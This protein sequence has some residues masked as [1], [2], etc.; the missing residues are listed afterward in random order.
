MGYHELMFG[1]RRL[2]PPPSRHSPGTGYLSTTS[3]SLCSCLLAS[4][5]APAIAAPVRAPE[6]A[7]APTDHERITRQLAYEARKRAKLRSRRPSSDRSR[8]DFPNLSP[9]AAKLPKMGF[10]T[11]QGLDARSPLPLAGAWARAHERPQLPDLRRRHA[12]L[13][14]LDDFGHTF[15]LGERFVYDVEFANSPIGVIDV[16]VDAIE[17][18]VRGPAPKGRPLVRL[19]A[20]VNTSG[21]LTFLA[22]VQDTMTSW[23]DART[24]AVVRIHNTMVQEGIGTKYRDRET[25]SE[26]LGRGYVRIIDTK[27]GKTRKLSL[28]VPTDTFGP[29]STVAWIRSLNLAPGERR[30]AHAMDMRALLRVEVVNRGPSTPEKMPSIAGALGLGA[31]DLDLYEG[32]L[33]RV[34]RHDDPLPGRRVVQFRAWVGRP[35]PRVLLALESD[36]WLGV[37]RLS[38]TGYDP[39]R[40]ASKAA[41]TRSAAPSMPPRAEPSPPSQVAGTSE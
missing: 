28:T 12:A 7:S 19:V 4:A 8:V 9:D 32:E 23:V 26:F 11:M 17:P 16:R 29:L 5:F 35:E 14:E 30:K 22:N 37:I 31:N 41:N 25:L 27:D 18:D 10:G 24:G 40:A 33:T 15:Q 39:P 38:L 1:A 6:S 2:Q 3:C 21:V 36:M 13:P 34:D 20:E